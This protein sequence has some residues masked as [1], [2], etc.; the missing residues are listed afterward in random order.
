MD[1]TITLTKATLVNLLDTV[2]YPNPD[3]P[4]NPGPNNPIGPVAG[5][6]HNLWQ[7]LSQILLNQ[8]P[9]PPIVGPQPEPWRRIAWLL[10]NPQPLLPVAGPFPDPWRSALLAR[11]V[12]DQAVAQY[13]Y[14]EMLSPAQSERA[15]EEIRSSIREFVD[16]Y[17]GTRPPRWPRPWPWPPRMNSDQPRPLDLL[18]AGAQFQKAADF[19][20]PLQTDFSS[21]ADQ[22]FETGLNRMGK[23]LPPTLA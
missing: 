21:A 16:D 10:L 1:V 20:N 11:A 9:L 6:S 12:I 22:L 17:C 23:P 3:D 19:D 4:G 18:V 14:T 2:L 5:S 7:F 13:R 8:Q 15:F